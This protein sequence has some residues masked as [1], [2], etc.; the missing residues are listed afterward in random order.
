MWFRMRLALLVEGD[1]SV[2][3]SMTNDSLIDDG[4]K[5]D[6]PQACANLSLGSSIRLGIAH[7]YDGGRLGDD[8]WN[9]S[10]SPKTH[11]P[12]A[13]FSECSL[14]SV[15]LASTSQEGDGL[16]FQ[17]EGCKAKSRVFAPTTRT[18]HL[19]G[20]TSADTSWQF[21]VGV[22]TTMLQCSD[23]TPRMKSSTRPI[24]PT[25][26]VGL[27]SWVTLRAPSLPPATI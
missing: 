26:R 4:L 10:T 27:A 20:Y 19:D 2:W 13:R 1:P 12:L 18:C 15:P 7:T 14:A 16:A 8:G 6:E 24:A 11:N 5:T 23:T 17:E 3:T 21:P 22:T 25:R 9:E